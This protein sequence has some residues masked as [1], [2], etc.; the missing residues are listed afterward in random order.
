MLIVSK[1]FATLSNETHCVG[2]SFEGAAARGS[3][4]NVR[5]RRTFRTFA[6]REV[7]SPT[8]TPPEKMIYTFLR[9]RAQTLRGFFDSLE[10][11]VFDCDFFAEFL[12]KFVAA[13][14][15]LPLWRYNITNL[16]CRWLKESGG[17]VMGGRPEMGGSPEMGGGSIVRRRH[18]DAIDA[19]EIM[20]MY[21]AI[22]RGRAML[23][24][25]DV[26]TQQI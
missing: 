7:F 18:A 13:I 24:L 16:L 17:P 4:L 20:Y 12:K 14:D 23:P 26:T 21:G 10:I 19:A 3:A 11:A 6:R 25:D 8:Y 9:L 22:R 15:I 2:L 5:L 1:D